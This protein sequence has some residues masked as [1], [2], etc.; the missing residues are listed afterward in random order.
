MSNALIWGL[1]CFAAAL[2]AERWT[3]RARRESEL[4]QA[5]KTLGIRTREFDSVLEEMLP[6]PQSRI[7]G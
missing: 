3:R 6:N 4:A 2:A 7:Q 1:A 5:R